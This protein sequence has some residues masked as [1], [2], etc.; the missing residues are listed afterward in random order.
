MLAILLSIFVL[1]CGVFTLVGGGLS[2][3]SAMGE[4]TSG[5]QSEVFDSKK[6]AF[7]FKMALMLVTGYALAAAPGIQTRNLSVG[8]IA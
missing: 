7:A 4:L 6:L 8:S 1:V 5:W 3:G 2:L